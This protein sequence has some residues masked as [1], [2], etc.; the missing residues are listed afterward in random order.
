[1]AKARRKS[2]RR[3]NL[4][5]VNRAVDR[6]TKDLKNLRR[7]PAAAA[8]KTET[9]ALHR[10]LTTVKTLLNE[11]PDSMFRMFEVEPTT[12]LRARRAKKSSRK[13]TRKGR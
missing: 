12:A 5:G 1:V 13:G 4:K 8:R 3:V 10:K 2:V 9:A 7:K 6:L 11:C